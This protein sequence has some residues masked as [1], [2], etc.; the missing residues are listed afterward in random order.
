[1]GTST[2]IWQREYKDTGQN[3]NGPILVMSSDLTKKDPMSAT[4]FVELQG[5]EPV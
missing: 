4:P 2:A 3:V 5:I 1:M